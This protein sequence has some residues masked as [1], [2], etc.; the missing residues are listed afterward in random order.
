MYE[1]KIIGA[2]VLRKKAKEIADF[3]H[4]LKKITDDML[5][6][7]HHFKGIGL[8]APQVGILERIIVTD[9]SSQEQ[10]SQSMVFVNPRIIESWGEKIYEEG[11]LSIPGVNENILRPEKIF[12][13][14]QDIDGK[15]KTAE[16]ESWMARVL[17]HEIDHLNGILFIDYLSPI[18]KKLVLN[19]FEPV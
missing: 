7:M 17:Q 18:K 1:I 2:D 4:N 11:C 5:E 10:G 13:H 9:V 6:T 19:K 15:K 12:L 8:A 14:Y 3:N 16:F